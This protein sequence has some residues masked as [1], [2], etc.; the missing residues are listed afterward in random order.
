ME[1]PAYRGRGRRPNHPW[2]SVATWSQ[3][4]DEQ[5]WR[6]VDVRDGSKGPLVVDI[7]KRRVVSRPHRRQPG[8]EELWVVVR[9]RDRDQQQVVKSDDS[10][11]NAIPETP[12]R[13]L[14]RVATAAHCMEECL[15]LSKSE[16]G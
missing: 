2:Q 11:S 5:A 9:S 7:V 8:D 13:T 15:Q 10:W 4:L 14:A 12:R 1:F 16:A 3:A 6:R